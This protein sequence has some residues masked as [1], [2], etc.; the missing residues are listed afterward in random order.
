MAG[1]TDIVNSVAT[2]FEDVTKKQAGELVDAIFGYIGSCLKAGD[3]VQVPGF[4]TFALSERKAREGRNPS[5]GKKIKIKASKNVRFK[6]GKDLK[7]AVN[8]K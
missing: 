4:G 1:K 3:R 7:D 6:A 2:Q 8:S 5:T